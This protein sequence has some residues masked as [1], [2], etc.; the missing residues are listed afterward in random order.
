[1]GVL[2]YTSVSYQLIKKRII[3][4]KK[5][6]MKNII[7]P[8]FVFVSS[9]SYA[10]VI[11]GD[12]AGTATN[13]TSVLLEF[14][15]KE[16]KGIVLP[17]NR[18]LP[19]TP[20]EGTIVLDAT[21]PAQA[22]VKYFNG[23]WVDLSQD[24]A[25]IT[26]ALSIQPNVSSKVDKVATIIGANSSNANGVLVLESTTKAM[27]LP[28]VASTDDVVNPSPG[29]MV[30]VSNANDKLLAVFNGANWSFWKAQ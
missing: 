17:Y 4:E 9:L 6:S 16:N 15:K 18:M 2:L 7:I 22:K 28:T 14:S 11:I 5:E 24:E 12:D 19:I 21:T 1:M 3:I 25:D 23:S 26:S 27:V 20:A 8:I 13:K 30:Y 29:M 10:Q